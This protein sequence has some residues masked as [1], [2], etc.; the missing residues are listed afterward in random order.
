MPEVREKVTEKD[1]EQ[2]YQEPTL[3]SLAEKAQVCGNNLG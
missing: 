2:L 3:V 1:R